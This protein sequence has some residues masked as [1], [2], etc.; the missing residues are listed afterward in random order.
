MTSKFDIFPFLNQLN[1]GKV[2]AYSELSS[3]D[4][5]QVAAF[6]CMGFLS[7]TTDRLQ[8]VLLNE[9][10]NSYV[11]ALPKPQ[12]FLLLGVAT[13]GKS[14]S[15]KWPGQ[16]KNQNTLSIKVLNDYFGCSSRESLLMQDKYSQQEIIAMAEELGYGDDELKKLKKA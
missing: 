9:F 1:R 12:L 8:V 3:E 15:I 16:L 13:T 7:G 10:V 2:N 11:F 4:Q 6:T 14:H 5:K